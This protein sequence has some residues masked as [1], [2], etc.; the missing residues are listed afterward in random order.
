MSNIL[1]VPDNPFKA[2]PSYNLSRKTLPPK[3]FQ[4]E[5]EVYPYKRILFSH[6]YTKRTEKGRTTPHSVKTSAAWATTVNAS[7]AEGLVFIFHTLKL[8]S[9]NSLSK[10]PKSTRPSLRSFTYL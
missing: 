8:T 9:K 7:N 5:K 3:Q 1:P 2:Q 4:G 10:W 6:L